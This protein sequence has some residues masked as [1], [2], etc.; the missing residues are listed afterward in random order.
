MAIN[1]KMLKARYWNLILT[2]KMKRS[3]LIFAMVFLGNLLFGQK[4]SLPSIVKDNF[5]KKYPKVKEVS[6]SH[7]KNKYEFEFFQ[8]KVS[9]TASFDSTGTWLETTNIIASAEVP[10]KLLTEISGKYP[11]TKFA[12]AEKVIT[13][14]SENFL[15]VVV[16]SQENTYIVKASLEGIILNT[17]VQDNSQIIEGEDNDLDMD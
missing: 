7:H 17:E 6:W 8:S 1:G 11:G 16:E 10:P 13:S 12:Y 15:R 2:L 3:I 5:N 4:V 9:Y 14:D